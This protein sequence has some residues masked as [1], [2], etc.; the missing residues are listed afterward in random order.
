[1]EEKWIK[2]ERA[3]A[4]NHQRPNTSIEDAVKETPREEGARERRRENGLEKIEAKLGLVRA[5]T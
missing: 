5:R 1:M 2:E 4:P 3:K